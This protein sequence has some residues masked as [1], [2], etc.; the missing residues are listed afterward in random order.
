M[1]Q[2]AEIMKGICMQVPFFLLIF[3]EWGILSTYRSMY[4]FLFLVIAFLMPT[5]SF[6]QT[7]TIADGE[8]FSIAVNVNQAIV[9][10]NKR[11]LEIFYEVESRDRQ[12]GD[13][14]LGIQFLNSEKPGVLPLY[15]HYFDQKIA[16]RPYSPQ[17]G[18]LQMSVPE[19]VIGKVVPRFVVY[20]QND[21]LMAFR[22]METLTIPTSSYQKITINTCESQDEKV[23]C[24]LSR[25]LQK[26]EVLTLHLR[27]GGESG[28]VV[29]TK[30][31]SDTT[32]STKEFVFSN[33]P[34]S[35][36]NA[37]IEAFVSSGDVKLFSRFFNVNQDDGTAT[38]SVLTAEK[39]E[40]N[41]LI[42]TIV[43]GS[44]GT[45]DAVLRIDLHGVNNQVCGSQEKQT[46]ESIQAFVFEENTSCEIVQAVGTLMVGDKVVNTRQVD[47]RN[48]FVAPVRE[49]PQSSFLYN[50]INTKNMTLLILIVVAILFFFA[51]KKKKSVGVV[52]VG[53]LMVVFGSTAY[54][55]ATVNNFTSFGSFNTTLIPGVTL[56]QTCPGTVVIPNV[57]PSAMG[58]WTGTASCTITGAPANRIVRIQQTTAYLGPGNPGQPGNNNI[59]CDYTVPY[60]A[61][62]SGAGAFQAAST[63]GTH[64]LG[65]FG[66]PGGANITFRVFDD[67]NNLL[68]TETR[69]LG[70]TKVGYLHNYIVATPAMCRNGIVEGNEQCDDGNSI[71]TDGCTNLCRTAR[72]GDNVQ[73]LTPASQAEQCDNGSGNG[74][75][76]QACSS[77]C[78]VQA[79]TCGNGAIDPG[80]QCDVSAGSQSQCFGMSGSRCNE[81]C[82]LVSCN[83]NGE[84]ACSLQASPVTG[85][86]GTTVALTPQIVSTYNNGWWQSCRVNNVPNNIDEENFID[87]SFG[88][89][90]QSQPILSGTQT[91]SAFCN[92]Y[93]ASIY[94]IVT[95]PCTPA[96]VVG[97]PQV[98]PINIGWTPAPVFDPQAK[99]VN[100]A[101][102]QTA[103]SEALHVTT[104]GRTNCSLTGIFDSSEGPISIT[105]SISPTANYAVNVGPGNYSYT[106]AC[107]DGSM[108]Q[109]TLNVN[110]ST[111]VCGNNTLESGE[112]CDDGNIVNGDGC[113]SLCQ[114]ET[115]PAG[116]VCLAGACSTACGGASQPPCT[117]ANL[118]MC[119]AAG[120]GGGICGD[121][122]CNGA[123][124]CSSCPQDCGICPS[125]L[126]AAC[127]SSPEVSYSPRPAVAGKVFSLSFRFINTGSESWSAGSVYRARGISSYG[128]W[129]TY[130][131]LSNSVAGGLNL[132]TNPDFSTTL[133][134]PL[135]TDGSSQVVNY[136]LSYSM[137]K[138]GTIFGMTCEPSGGVVEVRNPECNDGVDNSD[139]E[140]NLIDCADPACWTGGQVGNGMCQKEKDDERDPVS[141]V[142]LKISA[143]PQLVR[144]GGA[145][146]IGYEVN[147]CNVINDKGA[148][149]PGVWELRQD[150][151]LRESGTQTTSGPRIYPLTNILAKTTFT[152]SCGGTTK[153][154][155]VS[156]IKINEI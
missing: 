116:Y 35:I 115:G 124:T 67:N 140:D 131:N 25:K 114:T 34:E 16:L 68:G 40:N 107:G 11:T 105:P 71:N 113:S 10:Q 14:I 51:I 21:F 123:E 155:T 138:N 64:Q 154:A 153:S 7:D 125:S 74:P 87:T 79:G 55:D 126:N 24:T 136:P 147:E 72:C 8:T 23:T 90:V 1:G 46:N 133:F 44:H 77:S 139:N 65:T 88:T 122:I 41:V 12:Y 2:G 82:Q 109:A 135:L 130:L 121:A 95:V 56:Y 86:V 100:L 110:A 96:T 15:T 62:C 111:P 137:S 152:V 13:L 70:S 66:Y 3:Y 27:Q 30:K 102:G 69:P 132:I 5:L 63:V 29:E 85:E 143:N 148:T 91:F 97:G 129:N 150:G 22:D 146:N 142:V 38:L 49:Q 98:T 81:Q 26:D 106:I 120:C 128:P 149:V 80:E 101:S 93:N 47:V 144:F 118:G 54:V 28:Y 36:R 61:G 20:G 76:P 17:S 89:S 99:T 32:S 33:K 119:N 6:S 156:V 9:D 43:S 58:T 18:T 60:G 103:T 73:R 75:L 59:M 108:K 141:G 4:K 145:S 37:F 92:A 48:L 78:T 112:Q 151:T 45:G 57:A 19:F 39:K 42:T 53:A 117:Y 83:P 84:F 127:A 104:G 31:L 94:E 134:A 52:A 50:Y